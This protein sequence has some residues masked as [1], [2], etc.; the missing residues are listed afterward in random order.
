MFCS[1]LRNLDMNGFK[2]YPWQFA[3]K[4]VPEVDVV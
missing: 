2:F 1:N 3:E 4:K